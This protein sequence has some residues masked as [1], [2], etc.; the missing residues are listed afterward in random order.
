MRQRSWR[1]CGARS[2][3]CGRRGRRLGCGIVAGGVATTRGRP[4]RGRRR[5]DRVAAAPAGS[6]RDVGDRAGSGTIGQAW[7]SARSRQVRSTGSGPAA[8]RP[9]RARVRP[10]ER[11]AL[12]DRAVR[13]RRRG[14]LADRRGPARAPDAVLRAGRRGG[15]PRHVVRPAAAPGRRGD[16]RRRAR[17]LPRRPAGG[18][19]RVGLVAARP[20]VVALAMSRRAAARRRPAARHPGR[21]AV[22]HRRRAG[23]G[24]GRRSSAG[25]TR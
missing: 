11:Q 10:L 1:R 4:V 6:V 8:A 13:G 5:V 21:G 3:S 19:D 20:I 16:H 18:A 7:K 9:P 17:G 12:A 15:L 25:P 2:R 22:D 14:R 23:A 24:P